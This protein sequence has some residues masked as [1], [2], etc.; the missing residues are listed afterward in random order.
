[1]IQ[2]YNQYLNKDNFK[3]LLML[4][5]YEQLT[6]DE[7]THLRRFQVRRS[8]V[9]EGII[10]TLSAKGK[11]ILQ[12]IA[13]TA[14]NIVNF[15]DN[16]KTQLGDHLTKVLTESKDKIKQKL[17][18]DKNFLLA[19]KKEITSDRNAFLNDV[20]TCKEVSVFYTTKFKDCILKDVM[21]S[22][23]N[24]FIHKKHVL[25]E[26]V[27]ISMFDNLIHHLHKI[28][29]F[30]W[31]DMLHHKGTQ[32]AH[33]LINGLSY[34]TKHLGG[35][36]FELPVISSLLGLAFEWN[37]K[38]LIKHG[39]IEAA[40]LFTIPFIGLVVKTAGNV[41]TFLACY[42]LCREISASNDKFDAKHT[43]I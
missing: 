36:S 40:E 2:S 22:L 35:P 27:D 1:M 16:L 28:P 4:S 18:E 19:V 30:A 6:E 14:S 9:N 5:L 25:Q 42:E 7:K 15:L 12:K 20:K 26:G 11:Q 29:P 13:S 24:L 23:H 10:S 39:L 33:H 34:I 32:G 37:I 3:E 31:L 21:K 8:L 38:G 43:I 41:A 17:R